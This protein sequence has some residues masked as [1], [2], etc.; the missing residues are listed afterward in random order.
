MHFF[1]LLDVRR[2]SLVNGIRGIQSKDVLSAVASGIV[3]GGFSVGMF[4]LARVVTLYLVEV[5]HIGLFLLHRF[6]GMVLYVLFITVNVGNLIVSYATMYK[7]D[8]VDF[9]VSLPV[10]PQHIFAIK[11]IDNFFT[12]SST[13][14]LLGLAAFFGYASALHLDAAHVVLIT[15]C[16]NFPLLLL[17]GVLA[18]ILLLV[19]VTVGG[20]FGL[21]RLVGAGALAYLALTY[22][23]F[24][25]SNP[26]RLVSE[27]MKHYPNVN[28]YFGALDPPAVQFLPTHWASE[29]LYWNAAGEPARGTP[30]LIALCVVTSVTVMFAWHVGRRLYYRSWLTAGDTFSPKR[31]ARQGG[32]I[33]WISLEK[34]TLGNTAADVF[35][36]RD[37]LMFFRDPSQWIHALTLILLLAVFL[38]SLAGFELPNAQPIYRTV[39]FLIVILFNGFLLAA[40]ALRF[41]FPAVSLEGKAFWSIRSAPV[42]LVRLYLAKLAVATGFVLIVS[43]F[44]A[45]ATSALTGERAGVT[46]V[47]SVVLGSTAVAMPALHL[48]AGAEFSMFHE[49]NPI[50]IASSRGASLTFLTSIVYLASL[51]TVLFVPLYRYNIGIANGAGWNPAVFSPVLAGIVVASFV[52]SGIATV[53]GLRAIGKD[54]S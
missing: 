20:K 40:I 28:G 14:A 4:F 41:V 47:A 15:V 43:Q 32:M 2:R 51:A 27:V 39:A 7:S 17:S 21:R 31:R 37:I 42:S 54:F 12:S 36:K 53:T 18:V 10:R 9:L 26:V 35:L 11:F 5:A 44:L 29:Y 3:F 48:G 52:I 49:R 46:L 24:R 30:S 50:R 25:I 34:Q 22:V 45:A 38:I 16:I 1:L 8:E 19:A 6:A 13:L 23:Y 33:A